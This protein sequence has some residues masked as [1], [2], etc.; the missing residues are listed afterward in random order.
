MRG[1]GKWSVAALL[2]PWATLAVE[3]DGIA[4]K[5]NGETILKSD[6]F[7]EMHRRRMTDASQYREV[8]D[9]LVERKLILKAAAE[10]KLTMQDWLVENRV[11]EI[12]ERNFNGDRNQL[13][14]VLRRQREPYA[15]WRRHVQEDMVVSAMRWNMI[16]KNI[17]PSPSAM[18]KEFAEHPERYQLKHR[19][20]VSVILL[21]PTDAD[22]RE[23]VVR[24]I[25]EQSFAEVAKRYSADSHASEGGIW[26]EVIPEEAFRDEVCAEIAKMPV[27][28]LSNWIELDGWSFLLRKDAEEPTRSRS[29][30]EAYD[31]VAMQVTADTAAK[32]Y[33]DWI[34]RLR[35]AS[36][37]RIVD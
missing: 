7:A 6:V 34:A 19:V 22:K 30:A 25:K 23:E 21:K 32:L 13:M 15:D 35:A 14:E 33:E 27:G 31:D 29:F 3:I 16:E 20:T 36:F 5:V 9:A 26:K 24:L 10:A 37:I 17:S 8:L 1:I 18:R 2:L 28:T 12:I 11:R 4:A